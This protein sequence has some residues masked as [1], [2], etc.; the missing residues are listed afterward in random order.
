MA[1]IFLGKGDVFVFMILN[2]FLLLKKIRQINQHTKN[3]NVIETEL[4][5]TEL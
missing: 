4:K 5:M 1:R 2:N 3:V